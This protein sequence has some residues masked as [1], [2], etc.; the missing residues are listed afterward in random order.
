MSLNSQALSKYKVLVLGCSSALSDQHGDAVKEFAR[1]GG[2]VYL[3]T[4][5]GWEDEFGNSRKKWL[6]YDVFK[7]DVSRKFIRP[8]TITDP[9]SGKEVKLNFEPYYC[10][11]DYNQEGPRPSRALL[12]AR[13][14]Q[15][16][17]YPLMVKKS[18]GKGTFYYQPITLAFHLNSPEG[19]VGKKFDFELDPW[20]DKVFRGV[21]SKIVG[22]ANIWKVDAPDLVLTSIYQ[23]DNSL[24]C[25]FFNATIGPIA[26]G[27]IMP[28]GVP[29]PAFPPM[30][31]DITFEIKSAKPVKVVAVSPDFPD[32]KA[33]QYTYNEANGMLKVTLNKELLK[34]YTIVRID[35]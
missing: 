32:E 13:N 2:T 22:N 19:Y 33:L 24:Y 3:T 27:E 28:Y 10:H 8:K 14:A 12:W 23:Q 34:A 30:Q 6:F 25:H 16:A 5:A 9:E 35:R 11:P 20:L 17:R 18:Y 15:N 1:N 26:K 29:E 21:L 7:H 31:K 4:T